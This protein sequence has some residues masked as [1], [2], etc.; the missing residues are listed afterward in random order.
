MTLPPGQHAIPRLRRF[1]THLY[2]PPPPVP[3]QPRLEVDGAVTAPVSLGLAEL[4]RLRRREQVSDLHCVSGW[5]AVGLRWEGVPFAAFYRA[6]IQPTVADGTVV[7]HFVFEG[8]DGFRCVVDARDALADDVLI[9][10]RLDGEPLDGDT[11][12]PLRLVSPSQYA[13]VSV[14]HL[15]RVELHTSEPAEN[16]GAAIRL[17]E[18]LMVRPLFDRHPRSRVWHEERNRRLPSRV[19]RPVYRVLIGPIA[20]LSARGSVRR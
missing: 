6:V 12:A 16:Y 13:F 1:G 20:F 8:L 10:D 14:K 9:A 7:T 11:G 3:A 15:C 19:L 4:G 18:L 17:A 5:S 2:A